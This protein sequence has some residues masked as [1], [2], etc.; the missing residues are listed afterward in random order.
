LNRRLGLSVNATVNDLD[1]AVRERG[2]KDGQFADTLNACESCRYDLQVAPSTALR[3]VQSL[4]DFAVRLK[5]V[6]SRE[7]EN[8]L[9]KQL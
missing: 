2:L 9:W 4:F 7:R 1:R 5:L 6:R 3:L 8:N